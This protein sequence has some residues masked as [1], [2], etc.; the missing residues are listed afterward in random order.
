MYVQAEASARAI[1]KRDAPV[2][3][4]FEIEPPDSGN[5]RSVDGDDDARQLLA[6]AL[7]ETLKLR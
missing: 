6:D 1:F 5:T 7:D 4:D 3:S 2:P